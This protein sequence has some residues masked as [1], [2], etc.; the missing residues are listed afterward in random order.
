M[1]VLSE[2]VGRVGRLHNAAVIRE[3]KGGAMMSAR[4]I[5]RVCAVLFIA[6]AFTGICVADDAPRPSATEV[7]T[8]YDSGTVFVDVRTDA[9]WSA[10]HLKNARHLP[11]DEVAADTS[12]AVLPQKD[13]PVVLYCKSG[14]R[15]E[16]AAEQLRQLG[17]QH[18]MAMTG[19]YDDFKAAGYPVVE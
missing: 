2:G 8:A 15:A 16:S 5:Q 7:R 12:A 6:V 4:C 10:G 17:Y 1:T 9:E 19:G 18:V 3:D 13:R 11:V 14:R